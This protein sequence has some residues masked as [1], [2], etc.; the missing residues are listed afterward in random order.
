MTERC[1][2]Y[3][4]ND[5]KLQFT[6][7]D[8]E[9]EYK[10]ESWTLAAQS[11]RLFYGPIYFCM[12]AVIVIFVWIVPGRDVTSVMTIG[13]YVS[14]FTL[15]GIVSVKKFGGRAFKCF[16]RCMQYYVTFITVFVAWIPLLVHRVGACEDT[17]PGAPASCSM[18]NAGMVPIPALC[19][20]A[21][22]P[23][24]LTL[25]FGMEWL[26]VLCVWALCNGPVWVYF[27]EF[28]QIEALYCGGCYFVT[29]VCA[30]FS[31]W[32]IIR[33]QREMFVLRK[34]ALS[35]AKLEH[36]RTFNA[37]LC[38]EIRNPFAV[39][40]GFAEVIVDGDGAGSPSNTG[41]GKDADAVATVAASNRRTL[42]Q[43]ILDS[44]AH[45]QRILDNSLDLGKL[46]QHKL[47]LADEMVDIRAVCSKIFS[48]LSM[49]TAPGVRLDVWCPD[50]S[51][52]G[53]NTRWA[54]LLLNLVQNSIKFTTSGSIL[55]DISVVSVGQAGHS[56]SAG[57]PQQNMPKKS[58]GRRCE[59]GEGRGRRA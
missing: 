55:L 8:V 25:F 6:D 23:V 15:L 52:R 30:I 31:S 46:E 37:F 29:A 43:H 47:V 3:A 22:A 13:V 28:Q 18:I 53:D 17:G 51:F 50:L 49:R 34:I 1:T 40:K 36:E 12:C 57:L 20:T 58:S 26:A 38:H 35:E 14:P 45:I 48:M 44:C 56:S 42:M 21:S 4:V 32:A 54:Q 27:T 59:G 39:I 16:S 41:E 11:P 19:I 7:P 33:Q 5:A 10:M 24:V 9:A 2:S